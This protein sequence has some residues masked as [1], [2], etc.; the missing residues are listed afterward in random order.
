MRRT[1]RCAAA[2]ELT[3]VPWRDLEGVCKGSSERLSLAGQTL[4]PAK[5]GPAFRGC[6]SAGHELLR[7]GLELFKRHLVASLQP[8]RGLHQRQRLGRW[9]QPQPRQ[10]CLQLRRSQ[11]SISVRVQLVKKRAQQPSFP[12]FA[13]ALLSRFWRA[14]VPLASL[15]FSSGSAALP[16][17]CLFFSPSFPVPT[18]FLFFHYQHSSFTITILVSFP[19]RRPAIS[20]GVRCLCPCPAPTLLQP[21]S[22][23]PDPICRR[24][25]KNRSVD[26]CLDECYPCSSSCKRERS[27]VI[28]KAI[29]S[30]R[31][32]IAN[33]WGRATGR[34]PCAT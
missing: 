31:Y 2:S 3:L 10:P 19:C 1:E 12:R 9:L 13:L 22:A 33:A 7:S 21:T 8:D 23:R 15:L 14:S 17:Q 30:T 25:R 6:V 28:S 18:I 26:L 34:L 16:F 11:R 29:V 4:E 5:R 32:R 27:P 24:P 20:S